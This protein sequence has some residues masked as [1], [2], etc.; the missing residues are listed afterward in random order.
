MVL[1]SSSVNSIGDNKLW[2]G[3]RSKAFQLELITSIALDQV[4]IIHFELII[5][6]G[7]VVS[8]FEDNCFPCIVVE[9]SSIKSFVDEIF[10]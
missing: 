10:S 4:K 2:V 3:F 1:Q 9:S 8:S 6:L 5:F 7:L